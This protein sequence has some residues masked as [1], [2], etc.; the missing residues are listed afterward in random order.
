MPT[1]FPVVLL[2]VECFNDCID[3][4]FL[5]ILRF[6]GEQEVGARLD[7][8]QKYIPL[9]R[10][11]IFKLE[12]SADWLE[13]WIQGTLPDHPLLDVSAFLG[14]KSLDSSVGFCQILNFVGLPPLILTQFYLPLPQRFS[15][16]TDYAGPFGGSGAF[17]VCPAH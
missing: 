4:V 16:G 12:R 11:P 2:I 5:D 8:V 1:K 15:E 9:L 6:G 3:P 14:F 7:H 10:N 17:D 13:G